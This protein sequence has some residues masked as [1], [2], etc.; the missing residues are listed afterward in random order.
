ML[1]IQHLGSEYGDQQGLLDALHE[2]KGVD[3]FVASY[4]A[5][6]T[7]TGELI[8]YSVWSNDVLTWLPR[9]D[10]LALMESPGAEPD[11]FPWDAVVD[12]VGH[13]MEPLDMYPERFKV[14]SFPSSED[15]EHLRGL[16]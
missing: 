2:R 16:Q 9:V 12:R 14:E 8:S 13:L 10:Q 3:V 4:S 15:L 7:D 1:Q 6:K 5:L 11:F